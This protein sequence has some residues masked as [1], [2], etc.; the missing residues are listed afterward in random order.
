MPLIDSGDTV[1]EARCLLVI[2]AYPDYLYVCFGPD[3]DQWVGSDPVL[4]GLARGRTLV[5]ICARWTPF[6]RESVLARHLPPALG[7]TDPQQHAQSETR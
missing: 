4:F 2:K 7:T 5:A 6:E 3:P 1:R